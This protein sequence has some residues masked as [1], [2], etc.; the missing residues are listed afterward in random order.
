MGMNT[1]PEKWVEISD[2]V[3][4][5]GED[6]SAMMKTLYS[7]SNLFAYLAG[8]L[9]T[10]EMRAALS[11]LRREDQTSGSLEIEDEEAEKYIKL[12][13]YETINAILEDGT[14]GWLKLNAALILSERITVD[15]FREAR[16]SIIRALKKKGL[17]F[18][19]TRP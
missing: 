15:D 13:G 8:L 4:K 18:G 2:L 14:S 7:L 3:E 12:A 1:P 9:N 5:I 10:P 6:L 19:P 11:E 17:E 16:D